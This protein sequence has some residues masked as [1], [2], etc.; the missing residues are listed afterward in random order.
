MKQLTK[1]SLKEVKKLTDYN[2]NL[3]AKN[4]QDVAN[5]ILRIIGC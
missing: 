2:I 5:R 3:H 4:C 1:S